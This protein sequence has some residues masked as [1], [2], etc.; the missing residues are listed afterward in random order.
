MNIRKIWALRLS[1][2]F[3]FFV[4]IFFAWSIFMHEV[5]PQNIATWGMILLLD[6]VGLILVYQTGNNDPRIQWGWFIAALCIFVA[7][8]TTSNTF[9]WGKIEALSFVFCVVSIYIWM[10]YDAKFG[11][12]P[13]MIALYISFTP[14]VKDYWVSPQPETW[15]LWAGTIAGCL[16]AIYGAKKRDFGNIFIPT[17]VIPLNAIIL[18]IVLL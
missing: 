11:L 3:G 4:P 5:P 13:Y 10:K 6:I 16:C 18:G 2:C 8:I 1:F 17:A 12:W 7:I 14:Q 9:E 15:W